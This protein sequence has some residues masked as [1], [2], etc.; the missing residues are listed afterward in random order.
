MENVFYGRI[1]ALRALMRENSWDMVILTG[2]DPHASEYPAE[3]W[4]QVEWLSGF[5]GEAGDLVVTQDHAGLWTDTRYFIQANKQLAGTGVELHKMRVPEQVPIPEWIASLEMDEPVIAVDGLCQPVA[6]MR[7][8]QDAVPSAIIVPVPDLLSALWEDRP[9]IP[10]TPI[11]TLGEDLT[12]ESREA[13]IQWLRKWLVR[14]GADAI[15]LTALDEIAW[16][17]NVRGSDIAYNPLVISYLLV[18]L[19]DVFWFVRKDAYADP[20]QDTADSFDE[21]AADGV[22][23]CDYSDVNFKL[24]SLRLDGVDRIC[25]DP[26]TL[27]YCL[28]DAIDDGDQLP[29][30]VECESPVQ[31]RK[32]VKNDVQIE[33]MR[34]AHLEDGLV[35]E[36]FLYWVEQHAGQVNEWEAACYLG[37]LRAQISGYR[38]DSFETISAY[39]P[40]AALPHYST[41]SEGSALLEAHGLYLCD[42]GGQYLFGTTDITRTV[43]MGPCT[44]LERED[45]TLVLK[46][47]ID[48]SMAVFP[49]G[50]CGP[51]LD[52]LAREPLWRYKRNFGHGTGHG[53]GFFLGVHEGPHEFRQNF[54]SVPFQAGFVIT[55]EPGLYRE[56]MHGVRHENVLLCRS[57]GDNEFGSWLGFEPLTLCHFDTSCLEVSL[58]TGD[59]RNWL[60]AY[61]ERVYRT[62]SPR[63]PA[64]VASWLR[65]KTLPV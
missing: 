11:I 3:R 38:G 2:S 10:C 49:K 12:G 32:A 29:E 48:L 9:A 7:E 57:L 43:P 25:V 22:T 8:L 42:S 26:S 18:T 14:Q 33:G 20:D 24:A 28:R 23:V 62:L 35:M 52:I 6:A 53:V 21:L 45:Y 30:V 41:P 61:H 60:N 51:H 13:R 19:D 17:L 40:S 37:S 36:Q 54:N 15:F 4:K 44:A 5:T 16:L 64:E 39:G 63:L 58:L 1:E 34:E 27:N 65:N 31:L 46:G 56:G 50:T 59:E 55:D 47:H